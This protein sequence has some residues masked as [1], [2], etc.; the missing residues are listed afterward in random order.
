MFGHVLDISFVTPKKQH[1]LP[2]RQGAALD[3][4][5]PA[6]ESRKSKKANSDRLKPSSTNRALASL[7]VQPC[8]F[9]MRFKRF[10]LSTGRRIL[11][12]IE[13]DCFIDPPGVTVVAIVTIMSFHER[14]AVAEEFLLVPT[15]RR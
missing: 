6:G 2:Y 11:S 14:K 3:M 10:P 5:L 4:G 13:R 9:A 8:R 7:G 1:D 12:T 15:F